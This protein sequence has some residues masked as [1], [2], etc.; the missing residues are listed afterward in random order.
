[1]RKSIILGCAVIVALALPT[2][3]DEI[4]PISIDTSEAQPVEQAIKCDCNPTLEQEKQT[5]NVPELSEDTNANTPRTLPAPKTKPLAQVF[6]VDGEVK[7]VPLENDTINIEEKNTIQDE[8]VTAQPE[9]NPIPCY[10][11]EKTQVNEPTLVEAPITEVITEPE[12]PAIEE[13][14]IENTEIN[15]SEEVPAA[16]IKSEVTPDTPRTLPAPLTKPI[17]KVIEVDGEKQVIF[18]T[19]EASEEVAAPSEPE[20]PAIDEETAE[21]E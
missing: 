1:M 9:E 6:I 12:Q 2:F 20:S 5:I 14:I 10:E 4:M 3:A 11:Q 18:K 8:E 7:V 15:S 21:E 16:D 19:E 17:A 13:V